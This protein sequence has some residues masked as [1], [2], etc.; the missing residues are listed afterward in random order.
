MVDNGLIVIGSAELH[1]MISITK[2][3]G[4][5]RVEIF[6]SEVTLADELLGAGKVL[7]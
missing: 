4:F 7:W 1:A 2:R 6:K 3:N 5:V